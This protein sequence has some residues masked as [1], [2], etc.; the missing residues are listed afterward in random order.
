MVWYGRKNSGRVLA[1]EADQDV[2][3]PEVEDGCDDDADV[4]DFMVAEDVGPGVWF[5]QG[6]DDGPDGVDKATRQNHGASRGAQRLSYL[7]EVKNR[8]P[9]DGDVNS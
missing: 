3:G 6:V 2:D 8:N 5:F 1:D 7:I 4:K 9:A